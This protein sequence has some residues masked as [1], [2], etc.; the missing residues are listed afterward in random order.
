MSELLYYLVE[1]MAIIH[2]MIMTWNDSCETV[3]SDKQLHF[4]VIGLLGMAIL[5]V[6]FPLFKALSRHHVLAIAWIYVFTVMVV[7]TFAIE[8][9]Q[10]I[11][12]TGSM[13]MEDIVY[14]LAGFMAMFLVFAVIRAIVLGIVYLFKEVIGLGDDD[15]DE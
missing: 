15:D 13:E 2:D 4:L 1:K 11:T 5:L 6:I 8:I 9:G 10:G 14:G 12:N 3:L 7:V